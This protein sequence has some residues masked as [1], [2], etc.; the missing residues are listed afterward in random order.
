MAIDLFAGKVT[1]ALLPFG[2][3]TYQARRGPDHG[4]H[5]RWTVFRD[6]EFTPI[7]FIEGHL[8]PS[9]DD[10][11]RLFVYDTNNQPLFATKP[12]A[13]DDGCLP[14]YT[15]CLLAFEVMGKEIIDEGE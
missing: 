13:D 8:C 3:H 5:P 7:G 6:S 11:P 9:T 14:T 2:E 15:N 12:R 1:E 4:N 10:E